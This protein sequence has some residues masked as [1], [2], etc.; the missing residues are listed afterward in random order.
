MA[1]EQTSDERVARAAIWLPWLIVALAVAALVVGGW[2]RRSTSD[3][4]FINYRVVHQIEAGHGPVFNVGERVEAFTSPAWLAMLV[5]ADE[6]LPFRLEWIGMIGGIVLAAA[7]LAFAALGSRRLMAGD[8]RPDRSPWLVPLGALAVVA[9]PPTYL[10]VATGLENGLSLAWLGACTWALGRW[11]ASGRRFGLP[12][13]ALLG[14]GVLVRPD[15]A[16][17]CAMFLLAVLL[18]DRSVSWRRRAAVLTSAA[19]LPLLVQIFRMGYYGVLLPNTAIAKSAG[20]ARWGHGWDY[21]VASV[22]PYWL[23]VPVVAIAMLGHAPMFAA[24]VKRS[25]DEHDTTTAV[26]AALVTG[27]F[28]LGAVVSVVYV[29]RVGGDYI[30]NRLLLPAIFGFFAPVMFV[31]LPRRTEVTLWAPAIATAAWLIVC[32]AFIRTF[33]DGQPRRVPP[34]NGVT[35]DAY[36]VAVAFTLPK[37]PQPGRVYENTVELPYPGARR[38]VPVV[39][40]YGVGKLAYAAADNVYVFDQLGLALPIAA[41]LVVRRRGLPGHE[42]TL[43]RPWIA[44]LLTEAGTPVSEASFPQFHALY[45]PREGAISIPDQSDAQGRP[46]ALRVAT[47]RDVLECPTMQ[48]FQSSYSSPLTLRLFLSNIAHSGHNTRLRIPGEPADAQATLC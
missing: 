30:P 18:G 12:A 4:A 33:D 9:F 42:K 11:A 44:A 36:S 47:A 20:L 19:A 31:R 38:T 28:V 37:D 22:G 34:A 8:H 21:L 23:W 48:R 15:L 41:H 17:F 7:G 46:F 1:P 25:G 6:T 40:S 10:L 32:G 43:P 2:I 13:A 35:L 26:R 27:A 3:D 39:I 14:A 16:T 5:V 29:V 45:S 24:A